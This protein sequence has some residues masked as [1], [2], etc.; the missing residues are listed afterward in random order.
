MS[1]KYLDYS[2]LKKVIDWAKGNFVN[3]EDTTI[4]LSKY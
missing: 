3:F 4:P 1:A 2:G